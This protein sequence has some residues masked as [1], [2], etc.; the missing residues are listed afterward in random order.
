[1]LWNQSL[2]D[3]DLSFFLF[4]I[5]QNILSYLFLHKI[6]PR[7]LH[8][9]IFATVVL[10]ERRN[11]LDRET[12]PIQS[13]EDVEN[14]NC[15]A[16]RRINKQPWE[17][18]LSGGEKPHAHML[19]GDHRRWRDRRRR[20]SFATTPPSCVTTPQLHAGPRA[21]NTSI[22]FPDVKWTVFGWTAEKL[23]VK[24]TKGFWEGVYLKPKWFWST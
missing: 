18:I 24:M 6:N 9:L 1:M 11:F 7:A 10:S 2:H 22:S 4:M 19:G 16:R 5:E 3:F 12:R 17:G 14:P 20:R 21:S 15:F 23:G 13:L 8:L